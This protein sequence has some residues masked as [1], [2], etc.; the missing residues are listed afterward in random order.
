MKVKK[1]K[2]VFVRKWVIANDLPFFYDF[3]KSFVI[4]LNEMFAY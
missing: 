3:F 4:K 2:N 1:K